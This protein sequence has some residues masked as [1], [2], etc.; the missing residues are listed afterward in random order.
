MK[1]KVLQRWAWLGAVVCMLSIIG[2]TEAQADSRHQ[3]RRDDRSVRYSRHSRSHYP[4]IRFTQPSFFSF[5]FGTPRFG[6]VVRSLPFGHASIV[7]GGRRYYRHGHVYY[8]QCPTGYVVV[9]PPQE[10]YGQT[11]TVTIAN[12]NGSYTTITLTKHG[13][14]YLGPQGEYYPQHPTIAQLKALYGA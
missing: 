4:T 9:P 13:S 6:V 1:R 12:T 10:V 2:V 5:S 8:T 3:S 14:G 7:T 11:S